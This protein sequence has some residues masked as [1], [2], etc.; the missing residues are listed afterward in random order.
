[1]NEILTDAARALN[2]AEALAREARDAE[3]SADA[4]AEAASKPVARFSHYTRK[5]GE[6]VAKFAS[7]L[8]G[9]RHVPVRIP[10]AEAVAKRL[11]AADAKLVR[12]DENNGRAVYEVW[13][14]LVLSEACP[15]PGELVIDQV[16]DREDRAGKRKVTRPRVTLFSIPGPDGDW[17]VATR[18]FDWNADLFKAEDEVV[19]E[20]NLTWLPAMLGEPEFGLTSD[21]DELLGEPVL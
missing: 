16:T 2:D 9:K 8:I 20:R 12:N 21:D 18:R 1:M 5:G 6:L 13:V 7:I 19:T 11:K 10:I 14:S 17:Y 4:E 15:A 3:A